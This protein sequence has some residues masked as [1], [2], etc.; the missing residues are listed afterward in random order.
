MNALTVVRILTALS[1]IGVLGLL[2]WFLRRDNVPMAVAA[3]FVL[4]E[5]VFKP[6]SESL[7]GQLYFDRLFLLPR[8]ALA[9]GPRSRPDRPAA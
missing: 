6:V 1:H 8:T 5:F 2:W 9:P 7:M 3:M 4:A